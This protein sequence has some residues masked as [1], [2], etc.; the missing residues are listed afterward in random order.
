MKAAESGNMDNSI[1]LT[2]AGCNPFIKDYMN[3]TA[4]EHAQHNPATE[5]DV[6]I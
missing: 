5:I 2:Q 4:I 1:R 3:C 6:M